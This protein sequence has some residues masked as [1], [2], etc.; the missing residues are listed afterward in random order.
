MSDF[1]SE[2]PS[3]KSSK[4][5]TAALL[6]LPDSALSL[7]MIMGEE[8]EG[9]EIRERRKMRDERNER[10]ENIEKVR[11]EKRDERKERGE[12]RI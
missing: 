7:P 1:H 5:L 4:V 2:S 12:G 9:R 11:I 3:G 6:A 8:M 10:G